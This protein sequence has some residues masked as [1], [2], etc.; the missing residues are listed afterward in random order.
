MR[1]I[2]AGRLKEAPWTERIGSRHLGLSPRGYM[3]TD[4][5]LTLSLL[6]SFP[7]F[8]AA[9]LPLGIAR[10][11]PLVDL[12]RAHH[13]RP[14]QARWEKEE[15]PPQHALQA[16]SVARWRRHRC[17]GMRGR[18]HTAYTASTRLASSSHE[19]MCNVCVR[20]DVSKQVVS[21]RVWL[22]L[23][24]FSATVCVNV[25]V[26]DATSKAVQHARRQSFLR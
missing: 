2:W 3:Y 8:P 5:S 4:L 22:L 15:P 20:A 6:P 1:P 10:P 14:R 19:A 26:G 13:A 25:G 24:A 12:R 11:C 23:R 16:W 17:T 21:S 7:F 18:R 9:N